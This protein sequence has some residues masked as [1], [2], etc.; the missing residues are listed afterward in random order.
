MKSSI[1][2]SVVVLLCL[3]A[4][5]TPQPFDIKNLESTRN[6]GVTLE[7][8]N[9]KLKAKSKSQGWNKSGK[10]D[11]YVGFAPGESGWVFFSMKNEDTGNTCKSAGQGGN[12]SWVITELLLSAYPE[13][14][15][16]DEKG[17]RFGEAQPEW[18][19][20]AFPQADS[21]GRLFEATDKKNGV[22][23]LSIA[24]ANDQKGE[25]FIYY[26]VTVEECEGTGKYILDPGF[27]NGGR[28]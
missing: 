9:K 19:K 21:N 26:R 27:G 18:L 6:Y 2:G 13:V 7:A 5:Q 12:A 14:T 22:T 20:E 25:R 24:N 23:F 11:G 15:S 28:K 10:K 1:L 3:T 16:A 17:E 8:K 4:C